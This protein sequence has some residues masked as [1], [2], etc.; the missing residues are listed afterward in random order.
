M[1]QVQIQTAFVEKVLLTREGVAFGVSTS[2]PHRRKTD[3]GEWETTARTYRTVMGK[4]IDWAQFQEGDRIS[5]AGSE[6]TE[7][8]EHDGKT[9]YNLVVWADSVSL[10]GRATDRSQERA[11]T[12]NTGGAG[13]ESWGT[14][15]GPQNASWKPDSDT[16]F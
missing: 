12:P 13:D 2:E 11:G 15:T 8:R 5:V 9:H 16:P 10:A 4:N 7:A 1:A 14:P 3:A 6:K